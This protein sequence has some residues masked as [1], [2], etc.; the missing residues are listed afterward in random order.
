VPFDINAF[1]PSVHDRDGE[2]TSLGLVWAVGP[3]HPNYGK[4]L[5]SAT[6]EGAG[7]FA[8]IS[9]WETGE[10]EV[11]TVRTTD[12]RFVNKHHEVASVADLDVLLTELIALVRDGAIPSEA[13]KGT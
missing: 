7:V 1:G 12:G 3:I 10:A 2:R 13:V 6:F 9:A 5:T 8:Q 11:E 4:A